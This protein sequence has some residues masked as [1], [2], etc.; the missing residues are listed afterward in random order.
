MKNSEGTRGCPTLPAYFSTRIP[1][2]LCD[3]IR[4][5]VFLKHEGNPFWGKTGR[6]MREIPTPISKRA[7]AVG[8]ERTSTFSPVPSDCPLHLSHHWQGWSNA[9]ASPQS[10]MHQAQRADGVSQRLLWDC[11]AHAVPSIGQISYC[12]AHAVCR[13]HLVIW[14]PVTALRV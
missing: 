13:R 11:T 5:A 6:A 3:Y 4:G 9:S 10:L 8:L 7:V 2:P 14:S 12:L 1:R